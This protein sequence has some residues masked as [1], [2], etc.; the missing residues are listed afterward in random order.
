ML[1]QVSHRQQVVAKSMLRAIAYAPR[2][3]EAERKRR[4]SGPRLL[5]VAQM[6]FR[7][8]NAPELLT[9]VYAWVRYEDG[10]EVA[11]KEAAA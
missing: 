9:R 10:I 6:R 7:R 1:E 5:M 2:R 3:A 11:G 8:L 4:W